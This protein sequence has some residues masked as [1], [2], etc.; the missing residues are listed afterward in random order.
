MLQLIGA[1]PGFATLGLTLLIN[2]AVLNAGLNIGQVATFTLVIIA[3]QVFPVSQ[4]TMPHRSKFLEYWMPL[5]QRILVPIYLG[6]MAGS[7]TEV[8]GRFTWV[9]WLFQ[10]G[11]VVLCIVGYFVLVQQLRAGTRPS[12][13]DNVFSPVEHTA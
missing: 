5:F 13:N 1:L 2:R 6:V 10:A 4:T 12:S 8:Y 7:M 9:R 11:G 3:S